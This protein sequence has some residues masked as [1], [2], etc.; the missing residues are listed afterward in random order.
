MWHKKVFYEAKFIAT[1]CNRATAG[2]LRSIRFATLSCSF[3]YFP[4]IVSRKLLLL[5]LLAIPIATRNNRAAAG[6]KQLYLQRQIT[7]QLQ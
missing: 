2:V 1:Q 6:E 4:S 5:Y 3:S 7:R